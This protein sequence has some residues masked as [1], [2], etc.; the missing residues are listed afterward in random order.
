M[1]GMKTKQ[2]VQG[3]TTRAPRPTRAAAILLATAVS[4]PVF[5]VL[6][7]IEGAFF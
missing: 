4:V 1:A 6:A 3:V 2:S 7:M 5:L